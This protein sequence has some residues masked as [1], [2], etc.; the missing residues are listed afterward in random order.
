MKDNLTIQQKKDIGKIFKKY[1]RGCK[2]GNQ[3]IKRIANK[4]DRDKA[5]LNAYKSFSRSKNDAFMV[6]EIYGFRVCPY[7]N[8]NYTYEV[9]QGKKHICRPDFDH[10]VAKTDCP[11][12]ALN[13][14]NL[15]P[16]CQQCNSRIKLKKRFG[17]RTHIHPHY[18][19]FNVCFE[20]DYDKNTPGILSISNVVVKLTPLKELDRTKR[21]ISDMELEA[22]YQHHKDAVMSIIDRARRYPISS[23][24]FMSIYSNLLA[25]N[26][27]INLI[28][29]ELSC[30]VKKDSLGKLKK[31]IAQKVYKIM[32]S[33]GTI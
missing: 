33:G 15:V 22:R 19:D 12:K 9:S 24:K 14:L 8:I 18:D 7:C 21:F 13:V 3:K 1:L 20:F 32:I 11:Q 23:A 30:D 31:D 25:R 2:S 4:A 27:L 5:F 26:D 29:P 28:Y 16:C 17:L 10:F 6:A